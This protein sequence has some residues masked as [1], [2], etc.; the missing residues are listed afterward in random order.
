MRFLST[1]EK[2]I[3]NS[4][5][6]IKEKHRE[7][8]GETFKNK[9]PKQFVLTKNVSQLEHPWLSRDYLKGEIVYEYRGYTYGC[10]SQD[11]SGIAVTKSPN[12][13]TPFFELPLEALTK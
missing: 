8:E 4:K 9:M 1:A 2:E 11:G 13:E 10:L 12:D 5:G 7:A 3:Y 6:G